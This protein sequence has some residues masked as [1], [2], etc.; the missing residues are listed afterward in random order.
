MHM[1]VIFKVYIASG[2]YSNYKWSTILGP[3]QIATF[4]DQYIEYCSNYLSLLGF[5]VFR[6]KESYIG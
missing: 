5:P 6:I 3:A 2:L 1:Y 4:H